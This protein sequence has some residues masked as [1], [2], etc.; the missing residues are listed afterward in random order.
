MIGER[1]GP[2]TASASWRAP[3]RGGRHECRP[4]DE[5]NDPDDHVEMVGHDDAG[6]I[7]LYRGESF[8]KCANCFPHQRPRIVQPHHSLADLTKYVL[9]FVRADRYKVCTN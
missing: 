5:G 9:P 1:I 7:N 8:G 2:R 4:Y 3:R 6:I